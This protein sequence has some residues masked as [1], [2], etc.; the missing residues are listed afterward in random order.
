MST[1]F[2]LHPEDMKPATNWALV[3]ARV[4]YW[5]WWILTKIAL[6][7]VCLGVISEGLRLFVPALGQKLYRMPMLY[8]LKNYQETRNLDIAPFL[9]IFFLIS[10]WALIEQII[11][12]WVREKEAVK[13]YRWNP[14]RQWQIVV[15]LGTVLVTADSI[16]FYFAVAGMSWGGSIFSV[17]AFLATVAYLGVIVFTS[18][19]SV[20]LSEDV[21]ELK[22]ND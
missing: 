16:L 12:M 6:G 17:S 20:C 13:Q 4:R 11:R 2:R 5:A 19:V 1:A 7:I 3:F 22:R 10:T 15:G 18:Y 21:Y 14:E 9:A 8:F